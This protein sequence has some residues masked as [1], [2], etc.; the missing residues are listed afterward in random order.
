MKYFN[1]I[2]LLFLSLTTLSQE[3]MT[4]ES[5]INKA[6]EKNFDIQKVNNNLQVAKNNK[7]IFN[8]GYLPTVSATAGGSYD[9]ANSFF[10]LQNDTETE[11]KGAESVKYNG[12]VTLNYVL[13]DGFNRKNQFA[14]LK[15]LYKL[16][17]VQKKDLINNVLYN[18]YDSYYTISRTK[19]RKK[20]LEEAFEISKQR[21]IRVSYQFNYGQAT[22][23]KVLNAKVDANN[24][25]LNLINIQVQ[26]ENAK[27]N[28]NYLIGN[29]IDTKFEVEE[30]IEIDKTMNYVDIS[31]NVEAN[32]YQ[33]KQVEFNKTV[34]NYDLNSSKSGYIPRVTTS[35][36]YS[37]NNA[38]YEGQPLF[39]TQNTSGVNVGLN[40]SWNLFDGGT[41]KTRV[42]NAQINLMNQELNSRQIKLEL[43]NQ[44]ANTWANYQ[45]QIASV[46]SEK[47]NVELSNQ[48][49]KRTKERYDLGQISSI[50]FR[51]AQLNLVNSKMNL[52]EAQFG[53]K[54][55]EL[56]LKKLGGVLVK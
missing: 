35:A 32:N 23:L 18:V 27:R 26:L 53:T 11:T 37:L 46:S 15:T 8:S 39:K 29:N 2:I 45:L 51:Q 54:L 48:N 30:S 38:S 5:A 4:L 43:Q 14:K 50:D 28:L 21:L 55:A 12:G 47:L 17:D 41:T 10:I 42:Q 13:F 40:L 33:L 36:G 20:V 44:L 19:L 25:S 52:I 24:D 3:K 56:Q 7:S 31:Q 34:S 6:M 22:K 9:N 1:I 16:A 49:F